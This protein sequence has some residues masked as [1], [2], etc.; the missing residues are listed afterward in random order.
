MNFDRDRIYKLEN[1]NFKYVAKEV[2]ISKYEIARFEVFL[3]QYNERFSSEKVYGEIKRKN[4][5]D[6]VAEFTYEISVDRSALLNTVFFDIMKEHLG[7]TNPEQEGYTHEYYRLKNLILSICDKT[8]VFKDID[9]DNGEDEY[10]LTEDEQIV[11]HELFS[12]ID[13]TVDILYKYTFQGAVDT[14]YS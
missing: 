8:K 13:R 1:N 12:R 3:K 2:V 14:M 11:Y 6:N 10:E 7:L 5:N 4:I 9:F